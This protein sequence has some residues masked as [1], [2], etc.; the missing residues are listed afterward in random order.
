M[1]RGAETNGGRFDGSGFEIIDHLDLGFQIDKQVARQIANTVWQH[2]G[3]AIDSP[4]QFYV[5]LLPDDHSF[6]GDSSLLMPEGYTEAGLTTDG[7]YSFP[8]YPTKTPP[9]PPEEINGE[10][11][12]RIQECLDFFEYSQRD[13]IKRSI[14]NIACLGSIGLAAPLAIQSG[15]GLNVGE[16]L[17]STAIAGA[18][19]GGLEI[20]RGSIKNIYRRIMT[21]PSN[22]FIAQRRYDQAANTVNKLGLEPVIQTSNK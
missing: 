15:D 16:I 6:D 2:S 17:T 5:N 1:S 8:I 7:S 3:G 9:N 22:H 12:R 13:S 4:G 10:F 19:V 18:F 20:N 21:D 14:A 11:A